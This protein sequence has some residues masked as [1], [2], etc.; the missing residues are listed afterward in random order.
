MPGVAW[1]GLP[2]RASAC[3]LLCSFTFL[4]KQPARSRRQVLDRV[5]GKTGG[6][7]WWLALL[8]RAR[9]Q[10]MHAAHRRGERVVSA[11]SVPRIAWVAHVAASPLR[12]PP[13]F[14]SSAA[15]GYFAQTGRSKPALRSPFC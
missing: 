11:L 8:G 12:T 15:Y 5:L 13:R 9:A 7:S 1:Q 14:L 2:G 3:N 4:G 6:H 10:Q